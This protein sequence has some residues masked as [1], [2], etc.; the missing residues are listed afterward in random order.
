MLYE[1]IT[2]KKGYVP[3]ENEEVTVNVSVDYFHKADMMFYDGF[4]AVFEINRNFR[5][6]GMDATH[7][8]EFTSIEFYWAYKTY[9]DLIELTKEYFDFLFE[10]LA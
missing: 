2:V 7:N 6:E 4:E 5:N 10:H 1:V 3:K 8:P 9:K